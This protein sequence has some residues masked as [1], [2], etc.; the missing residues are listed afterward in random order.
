MCRQFFYAQRKANGEIS[1]A[2]NHFLSWAFLT[3]WFILT[4]KGEEHLGGVEFLEC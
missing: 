1:I 2:A 3:F 4:T